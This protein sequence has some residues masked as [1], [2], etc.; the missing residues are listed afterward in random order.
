M[1]IDCVRPCGGLKD[2]L[3]KGEKASVNDSR[4]PKIPKNNHLWVIGG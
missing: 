3:I 4:N 1:R 2:Q